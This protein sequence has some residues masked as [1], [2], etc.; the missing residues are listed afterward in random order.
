MRVVGE[1]TFLAGGLRGVLRE[2]KK[3]VGEGYLPMDREAVDEDM[4]ALLRGHLA[5]ALE[6]DEEERSLLVV[7][8]GV[9]THHDEVE[10]NGNV[11]HLVGMK[12]RN[13]RVRVGDHV[14]ALGDELQYAAD[15][16]DFESVEERLIS[17]GVARVGGRCLRR[18]SAAL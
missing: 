10:E 18:G 7:Q 17:R 2:E 15:L 11:G 16:E 1:L 6:E 14:S 9:V 4:E 5:E 3:R 13:S 8:P 12:G